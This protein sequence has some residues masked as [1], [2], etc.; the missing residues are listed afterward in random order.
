M[1]L[2]AFRECIVVSNILELFAFFYSGKG[3]TTGSSGYVD[4]YDSHLKF[5]NGI[6]CYIVEDS[7]INLSK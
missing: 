6:P 7:Y 3:I 5:F 1:S 2:N 4:L